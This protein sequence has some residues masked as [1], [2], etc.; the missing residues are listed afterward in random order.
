MTERARHRS[1]RE[2]V[3]DARQVTDLGAIDTGRQAVRVFAS[4]PG[5]R[6]IAATAALAWMVRG[7]LGGAGVGEAL[8]IAAVVAWWPLQEWLAHRYLL[9]LRPRTTRLGTL[10][11]LFARRHRW[12]HEHPGDVD[13][14]LLPP[15]VI[16]AAIPLAGALFAA[17]LGPRRSALGAFA[18]YS[19]AALLYEWT[20]FIVHT[21]VPARGAYF[22]AL[23]RNHLL[24]HFRSEHYWFGF[25]VPVV[26]RVLG[27]APDAA[28]VPRSRTATDLY[29]LR[30][31][32]RADVSR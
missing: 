7:G 28:T 27:T 4:R 16:Y 23:R 32:E 8:A 1:S 14:T 17:L 30:E 13:G 10:D 18:A 29:G 5:P 20:H 31:A 25:T 12:H 6:A 11:P 2:S 15:A 22:K 9:H 19:T 24:H 26:D 21:R 3:S